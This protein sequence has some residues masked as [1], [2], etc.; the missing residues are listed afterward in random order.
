MRG[1]RSLVADVGLFGLSIAFAWALWYTVREELDSSGRLDVTIDFE[2]EQGLDVVPRS[3]K[4][5]V[6]VEG[7][8]RQIDAL[9]SRPSVRVARRVSLAEMSANGDETPRTFGREE[10]DLAEALGG[11]KLAVTSMSPPVVTVSLVRVEEQHRLVAPPEVEGAAE[12]GLRVV[13]QS[14]TQAARVRGAAAA[15]SRVAEVRTFIPRERLQAA[16]RELRDRSV[17]ALD[18]RL[19]VDPGQRDLFTLVQPTELTARIELSRVAAQELVVPLHLVA[20]ARRIDARPRR[21]RFAELNKADFVPGDP[22]KVRLTVS[23]AGGVLATLAPDKVH[24][25][26]LASDLPGDQSNGDVPVHVADLPPGVA[27]Q[28]EPTVYV[29]EVR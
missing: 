16:A 2:P 18:V 13:V 29:E 27:L 11:G 24:A 10:L 28:R 22:P 4:V 5:G 6:E 7:P 23:G 17:A 19:D 26:V 8:R 20:D 25:F 21:I 12:L 3:V 14:S 15:L 9:L 1:A